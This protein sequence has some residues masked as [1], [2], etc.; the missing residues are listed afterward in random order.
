MNKTN[1]LSVKDIEELALKV[2]SH[3]N[4]KVDEYFPILSIIEKLDNEGKLYLEIVSDDE[5]RDEYALYIVESNTIRV[6]ESVYNECY[7]GEYRSNFTLAHEFFHFM[8]AK[9]LNFDFFEDDKVKAY[10]DVEWQANEFAG[11]LL[12]PTP[13]IN[14]DYQELARKFHVSEECALTRQL[15]AKKRKNYKKI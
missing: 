3:F 10:C 15:N 14:L 5:L 6:K 7:N 9:I 12:I 4:I 11:Q 13:Y 8:Q 2:R 1:P